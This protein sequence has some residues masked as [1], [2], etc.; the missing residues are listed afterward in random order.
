MTTAATT[1]AEGAAITTEEPCQASSSS[2]DRNLFGDSTEMSNARRVSIGSRIVEGARRLS[3][4][5]ETT[6]K[7]SREGGI[8]TPRLGEE[9]GVIV[10]QGAE[11]G[12][13]GNEDSASKWS[14]QRRSK[15]EPG[16]SSDDS[17]SVLNKSI[18]SEGEKSSRNDRGGGSSVD[19]T[20]GRKAQFADEPN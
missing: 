19:T 11:F 16:Q 7:Q 2:P 9:G 20:G 13:G 18:E 10:N 6:L 15:Q 8:E 12:E 5:V 1:T 14:G 17:M 3:H 4:S